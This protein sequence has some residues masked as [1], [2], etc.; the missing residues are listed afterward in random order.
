MLNLKASCIGY[1][2]FSPW[3]SSKFPEGSLQHFPQHVLKVPP[4]ISL[5]V[6]QDGGG[7]SNTERAI[8]RQPGYR[9]VILV[10]FPQSDPQDFHNES[11]Q[12]S[13]NIPLGLPYASPI[14]SKRRIPPERCGALW[15][16]TLPYGAIRGHTGEGGGK[17]GRRGG[18]GEGGA[19]GEGGRRKG[20]K[21]GAWKGWLRFP[22]PPGGNTVEGRPNAVS[23]KTTPL[24]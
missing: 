13:L 14:R 20:V 4:R 2:K 10:G 19:A 9:P 11:P 3:I 21:R 22:N 15:N 16:P 1:L 18:M 5:K 6:P 12:I 24:D 17:G 8:N 7:L 23:A